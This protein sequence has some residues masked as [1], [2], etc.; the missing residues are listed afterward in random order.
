M[1]PRG[2]PSWSGVSPISEIPAHLDRLT[3]VAAQYGSLAAVAIVLAVALVEALILP[4]R[5]WTKAVWGLGVV[6]CGVAAFVLLRMEQQA[7]SGET[8]ERLGRNAA[9]EIASLRGLWSQW[10]TLSKSLPQPSGESPAASFDTVDDAVASLS[11]KVAVIEDQIAALN[12]KTANTSRLVDPATAA[13]LS[14]YL[15][16]YG[17]Q[18]VVV[19]CLP[20]DLE[21]Y[22]YANQ[23]VAIFKAAGWDAGGP[24]TTVNAVDEPA[25]GVTILV[26]DPASPD[27]AKI[28]VAAFDRFNIPHQPGIAADYAI[29]DTATVEVFVA[30]K[31]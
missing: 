6:L 4:R 27:A 22:S 14:D 25:I 1:P 20:G 18:R 16:S 21:A 11:A 28:L 30:K 23:L 19:S 7:S 29:P 15:R 3:A 12:T 10:D 24:E 26:R 8:A 17:G 5:Y 9:S 13:K 2:L 31:P